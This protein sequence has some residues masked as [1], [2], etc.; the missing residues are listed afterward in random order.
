MSIISKIYG[1]YIEENMSQDQEHVNYFVLVNERRIFTTPNFALLQHFVTSCDNI[2]TLIASCE[3]FLRCMTFEYPIKLSEVKNFAQPEKIWSH[4]LKFFKMS[5]TVSSITRPEYIIEEP[6]P[7]DEKI[8]NVFSF[9]DEMLISLHMFTSKYSE[10][11]TDPQSADTF[12]STK[13]RSL[14]ENELTISSQVS[15]RG[16]NH[17]LYKPQENIFMEILEKDIFE[18]TNGIPVVA[19]RVEQ[20]EGSIHTEGDSKYERII[21]LDN[22]SLYSGPLLGDYPHGQGKEFMPDGASYVGNFSKGFW[23]GQGYIVDKQNQ[24]FHADFFEGRISGV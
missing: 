15:N 8:L 24:M 11:F 1:F 22:G 18:M 17:V 6:T 13:I 2:E 20:S 23:H 5:L 10:F 12:I 3:S 7:V 16:G 21:K 14:N 4:P 19:K 9:D